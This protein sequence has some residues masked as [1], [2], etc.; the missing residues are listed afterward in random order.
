MKYMLMICDDESLPLSP[1]EIALDPGHAAWVA[2]M[3]GRGVLVGGG[4]LRGSGDA[5]SVRTREG[6][7]LISDGPFVETKEQIGGYA[8]VECVDLDEAIEVAS[9]HPVA[10]LGVVEVRPFWV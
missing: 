2:E 4:R 8:V 5:T 6:E 7:V 9:K 3:E 1:E 10:K